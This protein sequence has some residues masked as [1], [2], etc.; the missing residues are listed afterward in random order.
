M[1]MVLVLVLVLNVVVPNAARSASFPALFEGYEGVGS[2]ICDCSVIFVSHG[3]TKHK[4]DVRGVVV[5]NGTVCRSEGYGGC[6]GV[7]SE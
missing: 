6:G 4:G 3:F 1:V 5:G 7:D 2:G